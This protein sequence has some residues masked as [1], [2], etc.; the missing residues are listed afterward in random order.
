MREDPAKG[1]ILPPWN[2]L[3]GVLVSQRS[4]DPLSTHVVGTGVSG[5]LE[6]GS[7]GVETRGDNLS[8][9]NIDMS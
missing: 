2:L 9:I 5:E 4:W 3:L 7:L 6:N 1:T 8:Y